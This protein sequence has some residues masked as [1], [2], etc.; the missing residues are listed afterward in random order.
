MS[1]QNADKE[2]ALIP[3]IPEVP[4]VTEASVKKEVLENINKLT[5][6]AGQQRTNSISAQ[7]LGQAASNLAQVYC[8]LD[9][10]GDGG[11][12][13]LGYAEDVVFPQVYAS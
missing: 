7:Q 5:K 2:A 3:E 9:S 10:C 12:G 1:I 4:E 6:R 11:N 8:M 13:E